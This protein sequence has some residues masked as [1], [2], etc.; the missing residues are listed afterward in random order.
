MLAFD[1]THIENIFTLP[2]L[3]S[4]LQS[5]RIAFGSTSRRKSWIYTWSACVKQAGLSKT[6]AACDWNFIKN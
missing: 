1:D 6:C 3:K 5:L 4:F 2:R